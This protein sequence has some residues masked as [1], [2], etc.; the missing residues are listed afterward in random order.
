[1]HF[2]YTYTSSYFTFYNVECRRVHYDDEDAHALHDTQRYADLQMSLRTTSS[3]LVRVG[4]KGCEPPGDP[5]SYV[6]VM[7]RKILRI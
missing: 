7:C 3:T 6:L 1:M 4:P 2:V 5:R